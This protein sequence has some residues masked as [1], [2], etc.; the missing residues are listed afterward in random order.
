MRLE[1]KPFQVA[2]IFAPTGSAPTVLEGKGPSPKG[3]NFEYISPPLCLVWLT[4]VLQKMT[5]GSERQ[6]CDFHTETHT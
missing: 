1:K 2:C 3:K 6:E 5:D 4:L